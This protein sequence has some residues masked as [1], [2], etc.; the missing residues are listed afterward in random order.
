MADQLCKTISLCSVRAL[1]DQTE[2]WTVLFQNNEKNKMYL[3]QSSKMRL[4]SVEDK[5]MY[6]YWLRMVQGRISLQK[7]LVQGRISIHLIQFKPQSQTRWNW[8]KLKLRFCFNSINQVSWKTESN[9]EL[10]LSQALLWA[11]I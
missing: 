11:W 4:M 6:D 7:R 8:F 3:Y 2:Q 5:D 9:V 1:S 10:L